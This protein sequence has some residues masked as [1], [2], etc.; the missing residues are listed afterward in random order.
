MLLDFSQL[1]WWRIALCAVAG[2]AV[3]FLLAPLCLLIALSFDS[4]QWLQFPPPGWTL[5]WYREVLADP[6]WLN[7]FLTSVELGIVVTLA[8]VFL[9]LLA[10]FA[11]ARGNFPGREMLR[12]FFLTPMIMP[13][14]VLG[15]ALYATFLRLHLAGTFLGF[16]LAHLVL[17]LPF[18]IVA[19]TSALEQTDKS[20]EDAAMLC[21]ASLWE[22]RVRVILPAIRHGIFSAAIFSFLTSWDEVVV[23]IFMASP[24]LQTLPVRMLGEVRQNLSPDIAVVSSLLVLG[25]ILLMGL[26]ALFNKDSKR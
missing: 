14:I 23:A 7:S 3:V 22:A 24:G 20:L 18:S 25:T 26:T 8:S 10:G 17:A 9:G 16:V 5:Q 1:G 21:G 11:L 15:I 4:S 2:V 13:S 6:N 19:I 12:G